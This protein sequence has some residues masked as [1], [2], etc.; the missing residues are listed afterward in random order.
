MI[1]SVMSPHAASIVIFSA[2]RSGTASPVGCPFRYAKTTQRSISDMP[3]SSPGMTPAMKRL[4]IEIVP[5]VA[6]E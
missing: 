4:A 2:S 3:S 1:T 6:S 5:P